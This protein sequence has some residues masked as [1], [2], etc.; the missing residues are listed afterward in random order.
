MDKLFTA[1]QV[2]A[3]ILE[4]FHWIAQGVMVLLFVLSFFSSDWLGSMLVQSSVHDVSLET[5]G[6]GIV[7]MNAHGQV[8]PVAVRM[9]AIGAFFIFPLMAMV[10]RNVY[11]IIRTSRGETWFAQGPTPFQGDV[12][13]MV[14][15]IGIFLLSVVAVGIIFS[16][17]A[18]LV[19]GSSMVEH[20]LSLES[21]MI[22]LLM[23]CLSSAFG[24]GEAL[25]KDVEGLV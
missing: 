16:I 23:L 7:V 13:R 2:I 17:I 1:T 15:E 25:E 10:F 22:G 19:L 24:R 14:R 4:V 5:Y 3:K 6:Y 12:T 18:T 11:L 20:V 9:F 8:D 21:L